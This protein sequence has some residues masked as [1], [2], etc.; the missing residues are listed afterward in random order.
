MRIA[1]VYYA[2]KHREKLETLAKSIAKGLEAQGHMVEVIDAQ[3]DENKRLT[4]YE[5]LAVG[6]ESVSLFGGKLPERLK[7]YLKQSGSLGGK[8]SFAFVLKGGLSSEKALARLMAAMES[9]GMFV[10]FSE[11]LSDPAEAVEIAKRLKVE[12]A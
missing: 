7:T 10:N 9:E 6:S 3:H 5:Y 2:A 8:R 11:V 4:I 12:R 1:V